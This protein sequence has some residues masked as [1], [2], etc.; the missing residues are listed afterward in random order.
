VLTRG[1]GRT[2]LEGVEGLRR[3]VEQSAGRIHVM[4]GGSVREDNAEEIVRRSGVG[5][6]HSRGTA[7]AAM[8]AAA[9]RGALARSS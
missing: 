2:A 1:G 4:A 8:I 7:I 3:L 9:R 5:E 6:I